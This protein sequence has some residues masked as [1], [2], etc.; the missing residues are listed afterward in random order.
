M[1]RWPR[2]RRRQFAKLFC[3]QKVQ[4]GFESLPLRQFVLSEK[5]KKGNMRG[6]PREEAGRKKELAI[7]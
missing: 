5:S 2:G 7:F 1:E 3:A 4:R 6:E